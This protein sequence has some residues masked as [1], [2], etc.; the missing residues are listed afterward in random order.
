MA[1][2][3]L[4]PA[5][6][7]HAQQPTPPAKTPSVYAG[8]ASCLDCHKKEAA[9]FME[10]AKG[11]LFLN[12]PR[13][14][15]EKLGCEACHGQGAKHADSGGDEP[16]A[17][18]TFSRKSKTPIAERNAVCLGCHQKTARL[19]WQGSAH[20]TRNV[21]CTDCHTVMHAASERA[22]LAKPTVLETCGRCHQ[23]RKAQQLRFSHMPLANGKMEC[24]SCHNPH[25]SPNEKLL[26][27]SSVNET[28]FSCHAEKRG[29]FLWQHAPVVETCANCHDSHGSSYEKLLKVP[30]PRLCQQCHDPTQHPTQPRANIAADSRFLDGRQCVNCHFNIHGSNHPSGAALT[31]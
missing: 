27:A 6:A 26:L 20:E 10:T 16:G 3:L 14:E 29:P 22:N 19:W 8:T 21:A 9:P 7:I 12:R 5:A 28:C 1:T 17:L 31:R 4:V 24:T 11:K 25:G 15:H 18:I 23:Q 30:K 2:A 13:T